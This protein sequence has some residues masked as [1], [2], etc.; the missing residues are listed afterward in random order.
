MHSGSLGVEPLVPADRKL[1][2]QQTLSLA[3]DFVART[4][5]RCVSREAQLGPYTRSDLSLYRIQDGSL[6]AR[7]SGKGRGESATVGAICEA[8]EALSLTAG[9]FEPM[10]KL[11]LSHDIIAQNAL[12][13]ERL[14]S[15]LG[16][17]DNQ[18]MSVRIYDRV[19][20]SGQLLYPTFYANPYYPEHVRFSGD[21]YNYAKLMRYSSTTG[22]SLGSCKDE[23]LIHSICEALERDAFGMFL[24][25]IFFSESGLIR[26]VDLESLPATFI[27]DIKLLEAAIGSRIKIFDLTM[28]DI[29]IPV[30]CAVAIDDWSRGTFPTIK[31]FGC[32]PDK[33]HALER[34]VSEL[35][36]FMEI[37]FS[38]PAETEAFYAAML[39]DEP[40][41]LNV[42]VKM[43]LTEILRR[44][45]ITV[46]YDEIVGFAF[47]GDVHQQASFLTDVLT[48]KGFEIYYSEQSRFGGQLCVGHVFIPTLEKFY[49]NAFGCIVLPSPRWDRLRGSFDLHVQTRFT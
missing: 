19:G 40:I 10:T 37:C 27:R 36:Q 30:F 49:M 20:K 14:T 35:A 45:S 31:G 34:S 11:A 32:S 18:M 48:D 22:V 39:K 38:E 12:Q 9:H 17:G 13:L 25:N 2:L 43:P 7:G 44:K 28:S 24:L 33:A 46:S 26:D 41:Y 21:N 15:S 47:N 23:V 8:L 1:S 3:H 6:V 4:G 16:V 5:L 29:G 42:C